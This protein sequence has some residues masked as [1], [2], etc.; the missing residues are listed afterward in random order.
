MTRSMDGVLGLTMGDHG[1]FNGDCAMVR[2][3]TCSMAG[4]RGLHYG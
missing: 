1:L 2:A 3:M 4:V